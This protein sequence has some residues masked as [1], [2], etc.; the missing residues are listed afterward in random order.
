MPSGFTRSSQRK[1][2]GCNAPCALKFSGH[3]T[4]TTT[5][6]AAQMVFSVTV[7]DMDEIYRKNQR[8]NITDFGDG[9]TTGL[10]DVT[11]RCL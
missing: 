2:T 5:A 9:P 1:F 10:G 6:I 3:A 4:S 11:F 8:I 7:I